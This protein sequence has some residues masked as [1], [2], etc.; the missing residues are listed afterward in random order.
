M[1][2]TKLAAMLFIAAVVVF[3]FAAAPTATA[4]PGYGAPESCQTQ[5]GYFKNCLARDEIREQCCSVVE[6]RGC[7]C[8]LEKEVAVPCPPHRRHG[9]PCPGKGAPPVKLSELQHLPCFKGLKC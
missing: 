4:Y 5:I 9:Q 6:N 3:A 7:L 2:P 1:A 8:Q